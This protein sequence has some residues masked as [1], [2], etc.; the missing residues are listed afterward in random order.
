MVKLPMTLSGNEDKGEVSVRDE[1]TDHDKGAEEMCDISMGDGNSQGDGGNVVPP[2]PG[3]SVS[4]TGQ[5]SH[6]HDSD[7]GD[8]TADQ[9]QAGNRKKRTN[10]A[11][12]N[13]PG[14]EIPP[15]P[16]ITRVARKNEPQ[17]SGLRQC[18]KDTTK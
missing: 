3:V 12:D 4:R 15:S 1:P 14:D 6:T 10:K 2:A 11:T 16:I 8:K 7:T 5:Q 17:Q 9:R 13:E 18:W